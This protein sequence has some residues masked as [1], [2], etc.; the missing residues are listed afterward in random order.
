MTEVYIGLGS[1]VDDP[2]DHVEGAFDDLNGLP[3]TRLV[4]RS[5][6][7]RTDPVGPRNQPDYVNAAAELRT[8]LPP[9]VLLRHLL[10]IERRHPRVRRRRWGQRTLDLDILLYAD[11]VIDHPRLFVP[12][13]RLHL[14]GFAL[15]PL[16]E[17]SPG[18]LIPRKGRL[19]TLVSRLHDAASVRRIN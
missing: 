14:R 9:L 17:I 11:R 12:H 16:H 4:K 15:I 19:K 1:N 2:V 10:A 18:L 7:F 5:G 3:S 8:C 6:L 13:P